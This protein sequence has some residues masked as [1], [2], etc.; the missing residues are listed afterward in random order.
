[1]IKLSWNTQEDK[2]KKKKKKTKKK[3]AI[4]IIKKI[5]YDAWE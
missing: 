3:K 1:M 5:L 4:V 2:L